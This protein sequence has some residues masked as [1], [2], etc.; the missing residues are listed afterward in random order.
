MKHIGVREG[1]NELPKPCEY[2]DLMGGT[3]VGGCVQ[4]FPSTYPWLTHIPRRIIVLML[5]RLE[6][7]IEDA[8]AQYT[9]LVNQ[10]L[11]SKPSSEGGVTAILKTG[12]SRVVET[13]TKN[14]DSLLLRDTNQT[15]NVYVPFSFHSRVVMNSSPLVSSVLVMRRI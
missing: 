1:L 13:V 3:G 12:L 10:V 6:M 8:I 5:G 14:K 11:A 7:D 2:F 4:T 15:C 9:D